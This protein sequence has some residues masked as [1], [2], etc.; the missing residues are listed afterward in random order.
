MEIKASIVDY[1]GKFEDGIIV[2]IGIIY[3]EEYYDGIFYYTSDKMI[4]NVSQ[5]FVDKW[6]EVEEI[7]DYLKLMEWLINNVEP[8]ETLIN[9]IEEYQIK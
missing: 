5:L 2:S 1:L 8:Y 7:D 4:M 6:G 9:D 3:K